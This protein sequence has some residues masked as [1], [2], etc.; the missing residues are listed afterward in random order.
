MSVLCH[1]RGKAVVVHALIPAGHW[2]I[3]A[4]LAIPPSAL[5]LLILPVLLVAASTPK[6][7]Y[8]RADES[9]ALLSEE[10]GDEPESSTA[11]EAYGTFA[12]AENSPKTAHTLATTTTGG[13]PSSL[14][15]GANTPAVNKGP[16]KI[17]KTLGQTKKDEKDL[18]WREVMHRLKQLS[19]YL[20]PSTSRKLQVYVVLC[21]ILLL[22]GRVLQPLLP[23]SLGAVVRALTNSQHGS[24]ESPWIPFVS[25]FAIRLTVSGAGLLYFFQQR[26][27]IP[28]SQYTDREMMMLCFNRLL[29]LSLA[30]HTKRNTG[31]VLKVI[32]R[33]SAINNLFQTVL[34]TAMPTLFDMAIAFGVFFYLYGGKIAGLTFAVMAL[35][36]Y[37]SVTA[38][39]VRTITRRQLRDKDI[40]QRGIISDVLTNWESVK[41]FTA[42]ARESNRYRD[43]VISYQETEAKWNTDYQLLYLAQTFLL[44]FGVL[45]GS[46]L[47]AF[48][49]LRGEADAA[50]FVVFI[51]YYQQLSSPLDRLGYLYQS[52]NRTSVDAEKMFALL[53]EATEVNDKPG[54]KDLV[55]TDGVIEFDNVRFSYDGK[56]QAL[57]GVSFTIGKGQSM[58][59]VGESGSG[60]STILRLLY[61]FYDIE[62]GVIRIDGQ[63]ISQVTQQS[64]RRAIGIVPQDS[65]LWNDTI[66]ANIS[67]GKDG[68]TDQEIIDAAKAAML[69][70]RILSFAEGYETVVGERGIRLSGGEKQRV[71]LARMFLKSPAILVRVCQRYQ[72]L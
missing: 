11:R 13:E 41:Y 52:L 1:P 7:S 62:S 51:Q 28:V 2:K 48:R 53:A 61:R 67:Y 45:S 68:A 49:V 17:P 60:K 43:A 47:I 15:S 14:P 12:D 19:P 24:T 50:E 4:I 30:Y 64:L 37:I 42:E 18:E 6:I 65:V 22:I 3:L 34:F 27:W 57:K 33:G 54:A 39:Q 36:I 56:V 44:A 66:G 21:V 58:A 38:T 69:H 40:K 70:E 46:M 8:E 35:Y 26:L 20:W 71:S 10:N 5:R 16:I 32:D 9:S 63:D 72:S 29:D 59:L 55:I 31:E 25:Y 23:L